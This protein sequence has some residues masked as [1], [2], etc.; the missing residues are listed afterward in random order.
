MSART[1]E[2]KLYKV[3]MYSK[4]NITKLGSCNLTIIASFDQ[5]LFWQETFTVLLHKGISIIA[6][7]FI[8]CKHLSNKHTV[9]WYIGNCTTPYFIILMLIQNTINKPWYRLICIY[10]DIYIPTNLKNILQ[11]SS[12]MSRYSCAHHARV[13]KQF[14]HKS[15]PLFQSTFVQTILAKVLKAHLKV[16]IKWYPLFFKF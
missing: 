14:W 9:K 2:Q 8:R 1:Y 6:T 4:S 11:P 12:N 16:I 15:Y 13:N 5:M 7:T 3:V 10:I